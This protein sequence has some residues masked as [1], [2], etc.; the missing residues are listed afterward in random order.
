MSPVGFTI[1]GD[2][3][4]YINGDGVFVSSVGMNLEKLLPEPEKE[5]SCLL[6]PVT[7]MWSAEKPETSS[8]KEKL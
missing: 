8:E 7:V 5:P 3:G 2:T 1:G 6:P 4:F